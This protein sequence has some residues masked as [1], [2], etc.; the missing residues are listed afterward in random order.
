MG[1]CLRDMEGGGR[2]R[3]QRIKVTPILAFPLVGGR[4]WEE[5]RD[6]SCLDLRYFRAV[7]DMLSCN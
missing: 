4:K 3:W 7:P 2:K 5:K 1:I 6:F